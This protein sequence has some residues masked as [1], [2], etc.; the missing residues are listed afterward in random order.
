MKKAIAHCDENANSD[1][2]ANSAANSVFLPAS[3]L[4]KC[5]EFLLKDL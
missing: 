3:S 5:I 4:S 2:A 1:Q